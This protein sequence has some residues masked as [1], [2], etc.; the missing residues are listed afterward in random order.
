MRY[1]KTIAIFLIMLSLV[2]SSTMTT[3]AEDYDSL[4]NSSSDESFVVLDENGNPQTIEIITDENELE[5]ESLGEKTD[6]ETISDSEVILDTEDVEEENESIDTSIE[7]SNTVDLPVKLNKIE[8]VST[9]K[10]NL[11]DDVNIIRTASTNQSIV[12][13]KTAAEIGESTI[14]YIEADTGRTGYMS[15]NSANDAAYIG[16]DGSY[17]I[18]KIS[19]AVI[20]VLSDYVNVV[21]YSS[22]S[23]VSYYYV[24][25]GYLLHYYSYISGST[26]K[27]ASQR[28]GYKPSYLSTGVKYYSYDGHY[29]YSSF[30]KMI[31]DY[32]NYANSQ[33]SNAVNSSS[34]YYNYYQYLSLRSK[35]TFTAS[36]MNARITSSSSAMYNSAET[37][38]SVQNTYGINAALM[39]GIAINESNYGKS[40]YATDRNNLFGLN[41]VDSNSSNAS[42]FDS[43]EQCIKEFA[44]NWMS[45]GYLSGN[46]SRY[47]GPHLGDKHSGI[48][49]KYA[50]DPYWGE[51]AAAQCY[52]ISDASSD[53][54]TY[55]IGI[56][57]VTELYLYKDASTS[58]NIYTSGVVGSGTAGYLYD[59]PVII[60]SGTSSWY[61]V[62]SDMALKSDRSARSVSSTYDFSRDYVYAQASK[63]DVVVGSVTT[64]SS[65]SSS[66]TLTNANIISKLGYTNSSNYLTGITVG[67]SV[68][69]LISSINKIQSSTT[70]TVKN[71]SSKTITS[72]TLSTGMTLTLKTDSTSNTY[73]LVIRGDVNGDG[74][75]SG[76]DYV[77]VRNNLD[78]TTTL[79]TAQ[80]KAADVNKDSKVS[81]VD[82]VKIRNYLDGKTTISQ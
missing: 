47:R 24:S 7:E 5:E 73:T 31:T 62:Q 81:G 45:C 20:K 19:G 27:M 41:A 12:R 44:Y 28:V 35:T 50:S 13:F 68:S 63:I 69:S 46:D 4:G 61:K 76:V 67:T 82:Y 58:T 54:G 79:T 25:N 21:D 52:Y 9:L 18:C 39:F 53:Y 14:N 15:T 74:K 29:F 6:D 51:K 49:V 71:T 34:P 11:L 43:V 38:I 40:T 16:T 72:G 60:L 2:F 56:A 22:D 3:N 75:I 17:T 1:V 55:T 65:S 36:Q 80:S 64:S 37:F 42:Y 33:H 70:V 48:N 78:G 59:Y 23:N 26:V 10:T 66:S 30:S 8:T 32:K 57:N 77:K